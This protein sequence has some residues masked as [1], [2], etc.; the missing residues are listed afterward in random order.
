M[1][2]VFV[3]DDGERFTAA[4]TSYPVFR[5]VNALDA[6]F[7]TVVAVRTDTLSAGSGAGDDQLPAGNPVVVLS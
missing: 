5:A 1:E 7:S 4:T 2:P 6:A 3:T